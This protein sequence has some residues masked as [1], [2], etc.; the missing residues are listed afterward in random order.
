[1]RTKRIIA[2]ALAAV[3]LLSFASCG[4]K[5]E[6]P[7]DPA[8]APSAT[9]ATSAPSF[10]ENLSS[11]LERDDVNAA[12]DKLGVDIYNASG[13]LGV[14]SVSAETLMN[15]GYETDADLTAILRPGEVSPDITVKNGGSELVVNVVNPY[16]VET[17]VSNGIVS[18]CTVAKSASNSFGGLNFGEAT[19]AQIVESLGQPYEISEDSLV[20]SVFAAKT[21]ELGS[22]GNL[23]TGFSADSLKNW[24][25]IFA[26]VGGVLSSVTL[27]DPSLSNGGIEENV[28]PE[29]LETVTYE[30]QTEI[31]EIRKTILESLTENF[32]QAGIEIAVDPQTGEIALSDSVLFGNESYELSAEGKEYLDKVFGVYAQTLLEG[33]Y[34]DRVSAIIFEGHTN[35]LGTFEYNQDLSE[36]RAN[37]VLTHCLESDANGLSGE[38]KTQVEALAQTV[39]RSYTDPVY[40]SDGEVDMEAS[41]RVCLKFQITVE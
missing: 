15:M 39:G 31:V 1:M 11:V 2:L 12:L 21:W 41:R 28:A 5:T 9:L 35:T 20:Y 26:F 30:E 23:Y 37:A 14:V 6:N 7:N 32:K 19:S 13:E 17:A 4:K 24:K 27:S 33:E 8:T 34:A 25:L 36:K 16:D 18:S 10:S 40:T 29:E 38:L 22:I 3:C